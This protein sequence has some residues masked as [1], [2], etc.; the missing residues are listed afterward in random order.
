MW[1]ALA[2][3]AVA[4]VARVARVV[5][6][7]GFEP[8]ELVFPAA[9]TLAITAAILVLRFGFPQAV[10]D[11]ERNSRVF[12]ILSAALLLAILLAGIW[13]NIQ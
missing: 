3:S 11:P 7:P 12:F 5:S 8:E 9:I 2:V 10:S 1:L 4:G 6:R 13:E